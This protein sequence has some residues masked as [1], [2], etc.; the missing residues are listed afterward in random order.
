MAGRKQAV[1]RGRPAYVATGP[2]LFFSGQRGV[3][4]GAKGCC[5]GFDEVA[6]PGPGANSRFA[7]VNR[8]EG[9]VGAQAIAIYERYRELLAAEGGDLGHLVRFHLYQRDKRFFPVFGRV[10]RHYEPAAR[11]GTASSAWRSS[12]CSSTISTH[13]CRSSRCSRAPSGAGGLP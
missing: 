7:W 10:R 9:P 3:R 6:G 1:G 11:L 2:L 13:S 8:T 5:T 4:H 12:P